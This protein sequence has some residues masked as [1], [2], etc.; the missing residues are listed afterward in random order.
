MPPMRQQRLAH[1]WRLGRVDQGVGRWCGAVE[2]NDGRTATQAS[3][4]E[5]R[6]IQAVT[7]NQG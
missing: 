5:G 2:S 3:K 7:N 4:P 1:Q 6:M